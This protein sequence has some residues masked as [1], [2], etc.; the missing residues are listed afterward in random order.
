M[1]RL[2]RLKGDIISALEMKGSGLMMNRKTTIRDKIQHWSINKSV[3][4]LMDSMFIT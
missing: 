3:Q 1:E 2:E 4:M